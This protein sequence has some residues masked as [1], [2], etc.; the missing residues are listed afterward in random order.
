MPSP[1]SYDYLQQHPMAVRDP[2]GLA[3]FIDPEEDEHTYTQQQCVDQL[4][5]DVLAG[6]PGRCC[7]QGDG[8]YTYQYDICIKDEFRCPCNV[9]CESSMRTF[10]QGNC[11]GWEMD[12]CECA[13][14]A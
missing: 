5:D 8:E 13:G 7:H 12:R 10:N 3:C 4:T 9:P 1:S 2:T 6:D 11:V 14:I